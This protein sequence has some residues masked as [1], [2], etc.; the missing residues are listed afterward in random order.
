MFG[1]NTAYNYDHFTRSILSKDIMAGRAF[2]RGPRPG[3]R[4]PDF[5]LR[6]L[7]GDDFRLRDFRGH[8]NVVL[9]FGSATCP[10]TAGSVSGINALAQ[11]FD[12]DEVEFFF[13]YVREAHPGDR[14][15]AHGS[16]AEKIQ[17]AETLRDEE[18]IEIPILVD[19]LEG[20][21]H[22][23]YGKLPNPT[24]IIDKSGRVAF[25]ALWTQPQVVEEA[26]RQLLAVQH[27]R[28]LEH[29]VVLGGDDRSMPLSY[30]A[31]HSYRALHRGG[32]D[33]I[34][35]FEQAMG[36]PGKIALASSRII[37]PV[38]ENP[39]KTLAAAALGAA[40]LAGG[41][42]AGRTLRRRRLRTRLPYANFPISREEQEPGEDYGVVGI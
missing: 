39:G 38:K 1:L 7:E 18:E 42:Y 4:A 9:T 32:R 8:K 31:L 33:S 5:E 11:E 6:T 12:R 25:R 21:V 27:D 40:V 24:Y 26:L 29:A 34:A 22:R 10:M 16:M 37:G 13:I 28:D 41:L 36:L 15:P 30:P 19:D 3:E 20:A 17:A 35:D 14:I 23:R 2:G